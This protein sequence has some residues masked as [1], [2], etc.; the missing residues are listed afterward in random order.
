MTRG[1]ALKQRLLVLNRKPARSDPQ[2]QLR[3]QT[4]E[5]QEILVPRAIPLDL[6][7]SLLNGFATLSVA[8]GD[9]RE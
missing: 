8:G 4:A 7:R 3:L 5:K 1:Q 6:I 2:V 9:S